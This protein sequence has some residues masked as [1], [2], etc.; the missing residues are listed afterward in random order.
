MASYLGQLAEGTN[1][2]KT[3]EELSFLHAV[4]FSDVITVRTILEDNPRLNV[5]VMDQLG[6]SALRLAIRKENRELVGM[7]LEVCNHENIQQAAL[8]AISENHTTIAELILRHPRYLKIFQRRR[9]LGDTDGFFKMEVESQFSTDITPLNLAAQKNNFT[10]VQLLLERGESIAKP[11]KFDC[12]CQECRNRRM[13]D[14]LRQANFRLNAYRGLASEAYIALSSE[15]P[16]LTAFDLAKE[17]RKLADEEKHFKK[18]YEGL[19]NQLSKFVVELLDRV[20]TEKELEMVLNKTGSAADW[21]RYEN[22]ARLKMA[23]EN[24]EKPFVAHPSVQQHLVKLWH[25]DLQHYDTLPSWGRLAFLALLALINPVL[26]L[27]H[28]I[29]PR[30]KWTKLADQPLVKFV[31]HNTSYL[32]FLTIILIFGWEKTVSNQISLK[33]EYPEFYHEYEEYR[34]TLGHQ[35]VPYGE[36]FP[37]RSTWPSVME[38]LVTLWVAGRLLQELYQLDSGGVRVYF[39]DTFN[40]VDFCLLIV[41]IAAISLFY[42]THFLARAATEDLVVKNVTQLLQSPA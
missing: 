2:A 29:N 19:A 5:D 18:E 31:G 32:L 9:Y 4:E 10:I 8:Q 11:D 17:L 12:A 37:L 36:N 27:A 25:R 23:V 33:S 3:N 21:D 41:H 20:W 6:R 35:A 28:L 13:F 26:I 24:G 15:D 34:R 30:W 39:N 16:F 1:S 38:V 40:V 14:E 42:C 22:L 7:L